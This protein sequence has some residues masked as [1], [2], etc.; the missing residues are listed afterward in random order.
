MS[1]RSRIPILLSELMG[2]GVEVVFSNENGFGP[3]IGWK[4]KEQGGH[5]HLDLFR[6]GS[7]GSNALDFEHILSSILAEVRGES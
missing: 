5:Y 1:I 2:L 3:V 4:S 6:P 7:H